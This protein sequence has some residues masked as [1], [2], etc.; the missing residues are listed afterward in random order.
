[1]GYWGWRKNSTAWD[2]KRFKGYK[3]LK[4]YVKGAIDGDGKEKKN[5]LFGKISYSS[6][7]GSKPLWGIREEGKRN[8]IGE[9]VRCSKEIKRF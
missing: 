3:P 1:M 9:G 7:V 2:G 8:G 6:G 4:K 5:K